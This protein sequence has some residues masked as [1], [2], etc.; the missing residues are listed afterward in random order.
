MRGERRGARGWALVALV[1][2][3][4][5]A[6]AAQTPDSAAVAPPA[7]VDTVQAGAPARA[8]GAATDSLPAPRSVALR[9]LLVPGWGQ[10][11]N[12]Q[13]V[14]AGVAAAA[15]VGA[16]GFLAVRQRQYIRY[17]RAALYAGCQQAPGRDVCADLARAERAWRSLGEPRFASVSAARDV[18]RGRRDIGGLAV[19]VVYALQALDAYVG[20]HLREF[21]VGED[22]AVTV[23]PVG[24]A[25]RVRF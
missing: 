19:A 6:A 16:V 17:R 12:R 9:G 21:D 18:A 14:R 10:V 13:P 4:T 22:L 25:A 15:V 11:T 20:A 1:L 8:P 3:L 5:G 24:L 23:G 2:G 7:V